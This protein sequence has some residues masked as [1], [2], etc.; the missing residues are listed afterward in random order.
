LIRER[1]LRTAR[2]A[3]FDEFASL[4]YV[5]LEGSL[6]DLKIPTDVASFENSPNFRCF[7][8]T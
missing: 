3:L 2:E 8:K 5:G 7:L 6:I 4:V 1:R